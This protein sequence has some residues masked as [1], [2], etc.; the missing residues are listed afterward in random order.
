MR[1]AAF[2]EFPFL[3]EAEISVEN[4]VSS[5][6]PH[7]RGLQLLPSARQMHSWRGEDDKECWEDSKLW[8]GL[9]GP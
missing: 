7:G 2:L 3:E 1:A 5:A 8:V 4:D 6:E 9:E